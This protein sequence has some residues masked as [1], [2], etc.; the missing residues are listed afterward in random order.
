MLVLF[1]LQVKERKRTT[2]KIRL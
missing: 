2:F 1:S